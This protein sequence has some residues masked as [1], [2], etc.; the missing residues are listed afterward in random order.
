MMKIKLSKLQW[1]EM[2]R[3]SGWMRTA[4]E[5]LS[6]PRDVIPCK[7]CGR[8]TKITDAKI[9]NICSM[10]VDYIKDPQSDSD[11]E[12]VYKLEVKFNPDLVDKIKKLVKEKKI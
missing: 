3:K 7:I 12:Y 6:A 11:K 8:K 4:I 5:N 10:V 2:G 9:C 1:E